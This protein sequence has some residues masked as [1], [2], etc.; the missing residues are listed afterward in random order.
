MIFIIILAGILIF[1]GFAFLLIEKPYYLVSVFVFLHLYDVNIPLPG[2]LDLRGL[3]SIALF[4]RLVFFDKKN[5]DLIKESLSSKLTILLIIFILYTNAIYF[6]TG[7]SIFMTIKVLV[8]NIVAFLIGYLTI[9]N[10]YGKKTIVTA[11]VL[12][13]ILAT[14]DLIYT[15][16][17][18]GSLACIRIIDSLLGINTLYN[19]N[20]FG[21][22]CGEALII[23][24]L[25]NIYK[26]IDK[27]TFF[28]LFSI[29]SLGVLISTSRMVIIATIVTLVLIF[30]FQNEFKINFRK[31]FSISFVG[32]TLFVI[33]IFSYSY[34]LSAMNLPTEFADQ[35]YWRLV[36]EPLSFLGDDT[37]KFTTQGNEFEGS[38]TWRI[39]K[40]GRDIGVFFAQKNSVVFF[41][42]GQGGYF[43]IGRI[44]FKKGNIFQYASHNFYTNLIAETGTIGL[45]LFLLIP[46]STIFYGIKM[47]KK[48][49]LHFSFIYLILYLF[50]FSFG[51]SSDL[52]NKYAYILYGCIV[53]DFIAV[54]YSKKQINQLEN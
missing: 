38:M 28:I 42:F 34:I 18:K 25:L 43:K 22:L 31:V 21:L 8:L 20:E 7:S 27:R 39:D 32:A 47:I 5:V 9:R 50:V 19:H 49:K 12:T 2:P 41:G 53:A 24:I 54:L 1:S 16:L 37:Q 36:Q 29:S 10:G 30:F 33:V 40:V 15:Y 4:L 46:I 17:V 35:I 45:F 26:Q 14:A 52:T 6:L 48:G 44:Q 51:A 11:I 13:G 3:I 23:T